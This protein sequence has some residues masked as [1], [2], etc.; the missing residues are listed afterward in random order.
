MGQWFSNVLATKKKPPAGTY[1]F[2]EANS[3]LNNT[4]PTGDQVFCPLGAAFRFVSWLGFGCG[5]FSQ[6]RD[7]SGATCSG[8]V[9]GAQGEGATTRHS[10]QARQLRSS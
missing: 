9:R 5:G 1:L 6:G 4:N 8:R 10:S 3:A 7:M 2:L